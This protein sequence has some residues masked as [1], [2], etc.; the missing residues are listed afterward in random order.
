MPLRLQGKAKRQ[1]CEPG[2]RRIFGW[3]LTSGMRVQGSHNVGG[4]FPNFH[5]KL[6]DPY[7]RS[8]RHGSREDEGKK[9]VFSDIVGYRG[10]MSE[11]NFVSSSNNP[12][13]YLQQGNL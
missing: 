8:V 12:P 6:G 13:C 4:A 10:N 2:L 11:L 9:T 7:I 5:N 3:P 1:K